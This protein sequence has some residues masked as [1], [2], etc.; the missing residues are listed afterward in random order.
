MSMSKASGTG[1]EI[2]ERRET[3]APVDAAAA[4]A[5][6]IDVAK[7]E[8]LRNIAG[9]ASFVSRLAGTF[10]ANSRTALTGVETAVSANDCPSLRRLA[11]S[12]KSSSAYL[13]AMR[14]SQL[15]AELE[16]V[17]LEGDARTCAV[18]AREMAREFDRAEHELKAYV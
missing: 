11:H 13:G 17:A 5:K 14:L 8:E 1:T 9:S 4:P 6:A 12:L 16:R 7:I 10:I 18:L 2:E 15:C 3:V